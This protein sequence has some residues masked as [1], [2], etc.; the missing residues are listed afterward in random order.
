MDDVQARHIS[1]CSRYHWAVRRMPSSRSTC[2]AKPSSVRARRGVEGAALGVEVHAAAIERRLD[3]ERDADA[4]AQQPCRPERPHRQMQ[5]RRLHLQL[6]GNAGHQF[7]ERRVTRSGEHIGPARRCRH[8]AT[9]P[10]A[11]DEIVDVGEVIEHLTGAEHREPR[12]APGR[13][14]SSGSAC[15]RVRRCQSGAPPRPRERGCVRTP[16]PASP[17]RASSPDRRRPD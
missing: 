14:T 16:R 2:G 7:V 12:R 3:A 6:V 11:L 4:F 5:P 8:F 9:Q 17:L 1:F 15:R 10:K 13:E